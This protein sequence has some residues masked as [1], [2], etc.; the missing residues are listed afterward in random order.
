MATAL[1]EEGREL[2]SARDGG[3]RIGIDASGWVNKRG[4]G[5][6]TRELVRALVS[7]DQ[8]NHYWLFLDTE[9]IRQ[10]E[11]LPQSERTQRVVVTTS[12]AAVRGAL[13][14][15]HRSLRDLWAMSAAVRQHGKNLDL[16]Y[17]P[18]ATTVFPLMTR[19]RMVVTIQT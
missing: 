2:E 12:E 7:L 13:V 11:D 5:R 6:Y 9:T 15:G 4:Q 1:R 10:C 14:S 19:A 8:R 18:S 3:L 17:F 16:F